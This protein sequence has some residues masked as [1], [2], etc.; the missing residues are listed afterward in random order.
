MLNRNNNVDI[1]ALHYVYMPRINSALTQFVE[2][3]NNHGLSWCEGI[4]LI[5]L[6]MYGD[7]PDAPLPQGDDLS[8]VEVAPISINVPEHVIVVLN[9]TFRTNEKFLYYTWCQK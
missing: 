7:D 2:T 8:V 6:L 1:F 4:I 9:E 5:D 3:F